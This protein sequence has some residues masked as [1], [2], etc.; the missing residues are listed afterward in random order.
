M[1]AAQRQVLPL[2]LG[3]EIPTSK[4][5]ITTSYYQLWKT[6]GREPFGLAVGYLYEIASA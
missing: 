6:G 4:M 1:L 2:L 3:S 5:P